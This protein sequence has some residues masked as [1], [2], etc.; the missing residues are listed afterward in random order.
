MAAC[1]WLAN[2]SLTRVQQGGLFS[3]EHVMVVHPLKEEIID[4]RG[5]IVD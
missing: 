1:R 2:R 4:E 3:R 5:C